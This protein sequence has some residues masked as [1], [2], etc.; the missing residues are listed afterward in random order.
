MNTKRLII[1]IS[2]CISILG[3][4]SIVLLLRPNLDPKNN[5]G[6]NNSTISPTP[7][8]EAGFVVVRILPSGFSP[9]EITIDKGMLVRF[10]NPLDEKITLVWEGDKQYTNEDVFESNDIATDVFDTVG[11]YTFSDGKGHTGKVEVR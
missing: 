4:A 2:I 10:T 1:I 3:L 6:V 7:Q 5:E 9:K 8:K 11:T